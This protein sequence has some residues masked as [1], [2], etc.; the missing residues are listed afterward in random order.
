MPDFV[1]LFIRD[2]AEG[3]L[4]ALLALNVA[5]PKNLQDVKA[6]II[7]AGVAVGA[8]VVAAARREAPAALAFALSK[9]TA[10]KTQ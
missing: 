8:A 4:A 6:L 10:L 5:A 3:A 1:K 7:V 2:A 9:I